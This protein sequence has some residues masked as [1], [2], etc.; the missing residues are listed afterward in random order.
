MDA[1]NKGLIAGAA[2]VVVVLAGTMMLAG[3]LERNATEGVDK[4]Y[5]PAREATFDHMGWPI[6]ETPR[7]PREIA[8]PQAPSHT[9]G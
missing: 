4:T 1:I 9:P 3:V 2:S 6:A 5:S 7:R 8:E